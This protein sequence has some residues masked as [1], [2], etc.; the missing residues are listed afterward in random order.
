[1]GDPTP[2]GRER[3]P[4]DLA[5]GRW[6]VGGDRAAVASSLDAWRDG[7]AV[8]GLRDRLREQVRDPQA[9]TSGNA[10]TAVKGHLVVEA[11]G[12]VLVVAVTGA[13]LRGRAAA[14][15]VL[16]RSKRSMPR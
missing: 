10:S 13:P 8:N 7:G 11:P 15:H 6:A 12:S 3:Y 1:M 2:A 16:G 4:T 5:D 9:V 14:S